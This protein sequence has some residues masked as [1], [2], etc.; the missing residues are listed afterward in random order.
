LLTALTPAIWS[1]FETI[2]VVVVLP[3]VPV[4]A[5][6]PRTNLRESFERISGSILRANTPGYVVPPP[7]FSV[8]LASCAARAART[9]AE[10]RGSSGLLMVKVYTSEVILFRLTAPRVLLVCTL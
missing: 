8:R 3:F 5:T 9:A 4:M 2:R 6:D 1:I 10:S 7:L